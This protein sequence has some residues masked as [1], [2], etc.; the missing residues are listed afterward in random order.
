MQMYPRRCDL[1][2]APESPGSTTAQ[3]PTDDPLAGTVLPPGPMGGRG[4]ST[5]RTRRPA[6]P[7]GTGAETP[8]APNQGPASRFPLGAGGR[9][10]RHFSTY[11]EA[12]A[13]IGTPAPDALDAVITEGV[14]PSCT[15]RCRSAI[16]AAR[17][18]CGSGAPSS[19]SARC[20]SACRWFK[21]SSLSHA[22]CRRRRRSSRRSTSSTR[23]SSSGAPSGAAVPSSWPS[24][25]PRWTSRADQVTL[26][27]L[28]AG[29]LATRLTKEL[30]DRLGDAFPVAISTNGPEPA[31]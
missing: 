12:P 10:L 30:R 17:S 6:A 27:C 9:P 19:W 18:R 11:A 7:A 16:R 4:M 25:F 22:A 15:A 5:D 26:A 20:I 28:Q 13:E 8:A 23:T 2:R 29:S 3:Q 31:N 1:S 21:P 24:R 14:R